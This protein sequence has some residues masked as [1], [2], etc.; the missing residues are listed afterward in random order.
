[1]ISVFSVLLGLLTSVSFYLITSK[2]R[3]R[4]LLGFLL[5]SQ[6]VN[7]FL[8]TRG[9]LEE[10]QPALSSVLESETVSDPL[11]QAL[12]LTAIVIS[13]A[14]ISFAAALFLRL[15]SDQRGRM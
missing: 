4:M 11:V 3:F 15:K 9:Y 12:I 10:A 7:L 13:F 6:V 2:D 8:F 5:L 14:M 1:M